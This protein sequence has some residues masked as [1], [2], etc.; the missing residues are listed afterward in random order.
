MTNSLISVCCIDLLISCLLMV[1]NWLFF[2]I[3]VTQS[4]CTHS[5]KSQKCS[6]LL[7][8]SPHSLSLVLIEPSWLT[9]RKTIFSSSL[10][11]VFCSWWS[12]E[13]F[14]DC[15]C[16]SFHCETCMRQST[17]SQQSTSILWHPIWLDDLVR[18]CG[19]GG[20]GLKKMQHLC[21]S[22]IILKS[23]Y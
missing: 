11:D 20:G 19:G 18:K 21:S 7:F 9:G 8:F 16:V 12:W 13:L 3:A 10:C 22:W 5:C 2:P 1:L 6:F 15:Y 4:A 17:F 14:S 23:W